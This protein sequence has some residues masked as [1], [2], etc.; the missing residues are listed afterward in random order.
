MKRSMVSALISEPCSMQSMPHSTATRMASS[1]WQW[2]ATFSPARWASSTM[3]SELVGG[4]LAGA[5]GAGVRHHPAR[6]AHLDDLGAVLDLVAHGLADL[7][8]AVG[9]ALLHGDGQHVG[10]EVL[11]HRGVEVAAGGG[12]GMAGRDDAGAVDPARG[13]W[14]S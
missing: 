7:V 10:G 3:A 2:A 4:V 1:P 12:D 14:P 13:R 9:D 11:E 8:D 6:G 5:G